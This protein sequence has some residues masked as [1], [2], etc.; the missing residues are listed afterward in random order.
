MRQRSVYVHAEWD[1]ETK[2][3][4]ATSEDVPGLVTEADTVEALD[5]KLRTMIPE[6]MELNGMLNDCKQV[7]M[8]LIAKR[9]ENIDL[10][11]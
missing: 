10:C 1:E 2:V 9:R 5:K 11:A 3:W 8:S 7:P 6:L 4:V